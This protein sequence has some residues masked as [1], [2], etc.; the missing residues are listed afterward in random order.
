MG[1]KFG[2]RS[3]ELSLRPLNGYMKKAHWFIIFLLFAISCLDEPDCFRL[4]NNIIGIAFKKMYDGKADTVGLID[5]QALSAP[6]IRFVSSPYTDEVYLPLDFFN[7]QTAFTIS[8]ID[9][10][11]H[12]LFGYDVKTQFVSDD[13]GARYVLSN[14]QLLEDDYDS[15]RLVSNAPYVSA[16]GVHLQVYRCPRTNLMK[17]AF[18][19]LQG[20]TS[21]ALS[22]KT[23]ADGILPDYRG[24]VFQDIAE[25]T[26][27]LPLNPDKSETRF[28]FNFRDYES[29]AIKVKYDRTAWGEYQPKYC[30]SKNLMAYHNLDT[31]SSDF[32]SLRIFKDTI[33]DP[34]VT[35]VVVY[36]CP[37]MNLVRLS[38]RTAAPVRADP[39]PI[40]Q[41]R[42]NRGNVVFGADTTEF[43]TLPLLT[44]NDVST[45]Q[46]Y[47]QT[48]FTFEFTDGTPDKNLTITYEQQNAGLTYK[49]CSALP[50]LINLAISATNFTS[51]PTTPTYLPTLNNTVFPP[52]TN[53]EITK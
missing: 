17:V 15:V 27:A 53:F 46:P 41:I 6:N 20:E 50:K 35:N 2:L 44:G 24:A 19:Q 13:C 52:S 18:Q 42:N 30:A 12:L 37:D 3:V 48:E 7:K 33:Q 45:G 28:V 8:T 47:T 16:A 14:L 5:I 1:T 4:N 51:G 26:V 23:S 43:F 29:Q 36:R 25:H 22:P 32:D 11:R 21:V 39:L 34:P 40:R 38:F 31:V 10:V 9:G 49:A